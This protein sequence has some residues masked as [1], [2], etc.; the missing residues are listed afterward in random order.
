[1]AHFLVPGLEVLSKGVGGSGVFD[2]EVR[3]PPE[4]LRSL[5]NF[6]FFGLPAR[7]SIHNNDANQDQ[8]ASSQKPPI[9]LLLQEYHPQ[10]HPNDRE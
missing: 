6:E 4:A 9:E 10:N 8:A 3:H 7:N 2:V 5:G 1:M